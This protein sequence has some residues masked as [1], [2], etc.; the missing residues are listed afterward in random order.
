MQPCWQQTDLG[1]RSYLSFLNTSLLIKDMSA[2]ARS[3]KRPG[4]NGGFIFKGK[5]FAGTLGCK[6]VRIAVAMIIITIADARIIAS[7]N[8]FF[9]NVFLN[10]T[11]PRKRTPAEISPIMPGQYNHS[12]NPLFMICT[13]YQPLKGFTNFTI[14]NINMERPRNAEIILTAFILF[15][16]AKM[17]MRIL[18]L[19]T[20]KPNNWSV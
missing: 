4:I 17:S 3:R 15:F 13:E 5:T 6:C 14:P 19:L 8:T 12:F 1:G 7:L 2:I 11:M 9:D 10:K 16:I 18:L 20:G